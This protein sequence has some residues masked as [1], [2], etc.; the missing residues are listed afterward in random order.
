MTEKFNEYNLEKIPKDKYELIRTVQ[1]CEGTV[2]ILEGYKYKL[3]IKFGFVDALRICDEGRRIKTYNEVKGIE[4]YRKDFNGI[5][6]YT[7]SNSKFYK[8]IVD[9]SIGFYTD[10]T[11]YVV[12]TI[13]DIV[14]IISS[15]P[16]SITI[17]NIGL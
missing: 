12:I 14:D 3:N 13:N 1:D 7:V 17:S 9:E 6:I 8:W 5:P 10:C 11:H 15:E 4:E 16:P 2:I